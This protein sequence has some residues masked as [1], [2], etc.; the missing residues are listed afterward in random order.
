[1]GRHALANL[2]TLHRMVPPRVVAAVWGTIWNRWHTHRRHG[3]RGE[4]TDVCQ[5]GC[6]ATEAD[7][8]NHYRRC[9][10]V[11]RAGSSVL[12]LREESL[13]PRA[14]FLVEPNA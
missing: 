9:R 8:I 14:F 2:Q 11:R 10:I 3:N 7:D 4:P 12:N 6:G 1:M 5:L 13:T